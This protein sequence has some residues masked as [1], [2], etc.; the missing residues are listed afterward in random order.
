MKRT[1]ALFWGGGNLLC[2]SGKFL[3]SVGN[4][5]ADIKKKLFP[6][7]IRRLRCE[8]LREIGDSIRPA[9][10]PYRTILN[11]ATFNFAQIYE[12]AR[13]FYSTTSIHLRSIHFLIFDS[14]KLLISTAFFASYTNCVPIVVVALIL[15]EFN[16]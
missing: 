11:D 15:L 3:R 2:S 12:S 13:L 7:C 10:H 8:P 4:V 6:E 14:E 5:I 1:L 9:L 16:Y